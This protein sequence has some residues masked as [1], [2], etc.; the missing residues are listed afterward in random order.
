MAWEIDP[1]TFASYFFC[2]THDDQY[3]QR[4]VQSTERT[5]AYRRTESRQFLG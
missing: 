2:K 3:R 5:S 1:V 4:T